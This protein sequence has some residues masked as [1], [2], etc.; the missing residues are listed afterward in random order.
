MDNHSLIPAED[1]DDEQTGLMHLLNQ[2]VISLEGHLVP[3]KR[4]NGDNWRLISPNLFNPDTDVSYLIFSLQDI[5]SGEIW[6]N[7]YLAMYFKDPLSNKKVSVYLSPTQTF[8]ICS[9]LRENELLMR[10]LRERAREKLAFMRRTLERL[11]QEIEKPEGFLNTD[12]KHNHLMDSAVDRR[13]AGLYTEDT[14]WR[15]HTLPAIPPEVE[16]YVLDLA[17]NYPQSF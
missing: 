13:D 15:R 5:S 12:K 6:L 1:R 14:L 7:L 3:C 11:E 17:P 8:F 16:Y 10:R 4:L 9:S 2:G